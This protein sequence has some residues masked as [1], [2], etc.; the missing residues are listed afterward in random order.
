MIKTLALYYDDYRVAYL[1]TCDPWYDDEHGH[2]NMLPEMD[3]HGYIF[4]VDCHGVVA[5]AEAVIHVRPRYPDET[6]H[7][8]LRIGEGG[9]TP[10]ASIWQ[11]MEVAIG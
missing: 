6:G 11:G 9:D 1:V 2:N 3:L 10:A 5:G 4:Y 7:G 8:T